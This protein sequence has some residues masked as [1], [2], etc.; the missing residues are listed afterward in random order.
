MTEPFKAMDR[1]KLTAEAQVDF[2]DIGAID[3][4]VLR[5]ETADPKWPVVRWRGRDG[6]TNIPPEKLER[7]A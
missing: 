7:I 6:E 5:V 3:G 2:P 4:V 1:V